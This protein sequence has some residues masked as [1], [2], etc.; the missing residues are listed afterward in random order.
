MGEAG[1]QL[2]LG[3]GK[4]AAP[5]VAASEHW[6]LLFSVCLPP[7]GLELVLYNRNFHDDRSLSSLS[8]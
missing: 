5:G 4:N 6:C 2:Q 7:L 1:V 8:N 3:A